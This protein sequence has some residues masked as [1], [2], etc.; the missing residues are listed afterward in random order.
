L[1]AGIAG[2]LSLALSNRLG[3]AEAATAAGALLILG[4]RIMMTVNSVGEVYEA[5]LFVEDLVCV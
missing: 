5:G 2:L 4:E 3:L 1:G